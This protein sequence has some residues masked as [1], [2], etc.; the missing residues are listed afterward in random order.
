MFPRIEPLHERQYAPSDSRCNVGGQVNSQGKRPARKARPT[1]SR[2]ASTNQPTDADVIDTGGKLHERFM[3]GTGARVPDDRRKQA[4]GGDN[5][6]ESGRKFV[7]V[8][9]APPAAKE[10]RNEEN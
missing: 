3:C 1:N 9:V 10:E 6:E 2:D 4:T 5:G 7:Y 8:G